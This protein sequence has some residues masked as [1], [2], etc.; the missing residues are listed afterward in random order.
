MA[1][2]PCASAK[3]PTAKNSVRNLEDRP[4]TQLVRGVNNSTM[5]VKRRRK[6]VSAKA[7]NIAGRRKRPT[8]ISHMLT[9]G[10]DGNSGKEP[11]NGKIFRSYIKAFLTSI[12]K[13]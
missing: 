12:A 7:N 8:H 9:F 5:I 13:F 2:A 3:N 6:K 4:R 1:C 11:P 10:Y